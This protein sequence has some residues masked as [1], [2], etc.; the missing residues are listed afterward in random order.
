MIG[1]QVSLFLVLPE[2]CAHTL[3]VP[4][5][6]MFHSSGAGVP[7]GVLLRVRRLEHFGFHLQVAFL[8]SYDN[9]KCPEGPGDKWE[10]T[11]EVGP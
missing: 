6:I 1:S 5:H 11:E 8:R 4:Q 7:S 3:G 10:A 9:S 2:L